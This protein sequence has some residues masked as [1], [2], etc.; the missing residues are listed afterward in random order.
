[1]GVSKKMESIKK[2]NEEAAKRANMTFMD[3]VLANKELL[4]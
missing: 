4:R 3:R 2:K 1:M